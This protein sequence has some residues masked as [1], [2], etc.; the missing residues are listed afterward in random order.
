M[1]LHLYAHQYCFDVWY[2]LHF[3]LQRKCLPPVT[4]QHWH[5]FSID[6]VHNSRTCYFIP[7]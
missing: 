1:S 2:V 7:T 4:N 3:H 5:T 6:C